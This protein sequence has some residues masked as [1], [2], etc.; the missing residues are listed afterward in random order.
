MDV[1]QTRERV[2]FIANNQGYP[3]LKLAFHNK[4][5]L[6]GEVRSEQGV[7]YNG[8]YLKDLMRYKK[9]DRSISDI[10]KR[11]VG[12][13]SGFNHTICADDE[14]HGTMTSSGFAFRAVD[15]MQLS[16]SDCKNVSTFPQ[17]YNFLDQKPK[18]ICGMSVPPNMMANIA[19]EIYKQWILKH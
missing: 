2:F 14:V 17:D 5:I 7:P 19:T 12:K 16:I 8:V 4:P 11:T 6:F 3:Q 9:G 10:K 1:P 18:Y 15:K 13:E